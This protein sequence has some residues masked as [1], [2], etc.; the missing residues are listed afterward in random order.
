[1][2]T[3][4]VDAKLKDFRALQAEIQNLYS[5]KT[6]KLSQFNENTLVKGELDLLSEEIPVYKLVGPVL[7]TIEIKE[8]KDN[9][10]KRLEF[11]EGEIQKLDDA[12]A[13]KQGEQADLSETIQSLQMKMQREASAA[14]TAVVQESS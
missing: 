8:A 11:I 10:Q 2:S 9:V 14:A 3:T 12:I 13:K 1:M 6:G 4:E 7:M 5:Q